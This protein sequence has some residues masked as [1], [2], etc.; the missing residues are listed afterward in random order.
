MSNVLPSP[1]PIDRRLERWYRKKDEERQLR[2]NNAIRIE[3]IRTNVCSMCGIAGHESQQCDEVRD[4][5]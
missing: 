1:L 2:Q 4:W 3:Q 5:Q